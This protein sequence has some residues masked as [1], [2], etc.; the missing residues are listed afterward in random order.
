[1]THHGAH[2]YHPGRFPGDLY[3]PH[4]DENHEPDLSIAVPTFMVLGGADWS[5]WTIIDDLL[6]V[7]LRLS[8]AVDEFLYVYQTTCPFAT[9]GYDRSDSFVHLRQCTSTARSS[10]LTDV[11]LLLYSRRLPAEQ[12]FQQNLHSRRGQHIRALRRLF[13]SGGR[14][15]M[16]MASSPGVAFAYDVVV[17]LVLAFWHL[18]A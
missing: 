10:R 7:G 3:W 6:A 13:W 1:M 15:I 5:E 17:E 4:I 18:I 9:W 8:G 12:Y 14:M 16:G 2:G 11:T